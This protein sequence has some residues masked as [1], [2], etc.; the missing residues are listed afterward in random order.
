MSACV[1]AN[2]LTFP[3]LAVHCL[4]KGAIAAIRYQEA[5]HEGDVIS[6]FPVTVNKTFPVRTIYID[7][8]TFRCAQSVLT[9]QLWERALRKSIQV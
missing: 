9:K 6:D 4:P 8:N 7:L 5:S 2:G 1:A 3:I